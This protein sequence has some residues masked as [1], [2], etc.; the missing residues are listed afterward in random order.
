MNYLDSIVRHLE[1]IEEMGRDLG[2]KEMTKE[3]KEAKRLRVR[4]EG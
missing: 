4:I 3:A 1:A 2:K